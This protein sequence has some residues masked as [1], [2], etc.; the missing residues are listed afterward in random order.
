[1]HLGAHATYNACSI[2]RYSAKKADVHVLYKGLRILF[3]VLDHDWHGTDA[4]VV[5]VTDCSISVSIVGS[6]LGICVPVHLG[7]MIVFPYVILACVCI[8]AFCSCL[9]RQ[10]CEASLAYI[11][12]KQWLLIYVQCY[13]WI[14]VGPDSCMF[15]LV[16]LDGFT[17][18]NWNHKSSNEKVS[19]R[20]CGETGMRPG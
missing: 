8:G 15:N 19:F 13:C 7:T 3:K 6:T 10:G 9:V 5:I 12:P 16:A 18:Y 17:E 4:S 11:P 2:C 14:D 1:M 20:C